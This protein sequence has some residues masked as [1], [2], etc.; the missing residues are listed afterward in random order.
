[1][2]V[3]SASKPWTIMVTRPPEIRVAPV[4]NAAGVLP[5]APLNTYHVSAQKG[6]LVMAGQPAQK[7]K[8]DFSFS[9]PPGSDLADPDELAAFLLSLSSAITGII[10]GV[11]DTAKTGDV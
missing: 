10:Q 7:A 3:H 6:L 1:V 11:I 5:T 9:I 4:P 8:A 2:T